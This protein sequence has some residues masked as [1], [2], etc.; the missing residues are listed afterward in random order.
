M[1]E[2]KLAF[3]LVRTA[4]TPA[5]CSPNL[6]T[7]HV[8]DTLQI[9]LI[10]TPW[11]WAVHLAKWLQIELIHA[12]S[13]HRSKAVPIWRILQMQPTIGAFFSLF[14]EDAPLLSFMA[15]HIPRFYACPKKKKEREKMAS[16][17]DVYCHFRGPE[18]QKSWRKGKT[19]GDATRKC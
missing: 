17:P 3:I 15:S 14:L 12:V 13:Q 5:A 4:Q 18:Q 2:H 16:S 10:S 19:S 6:T 1:V 8:S 7:L 9:L 11:V